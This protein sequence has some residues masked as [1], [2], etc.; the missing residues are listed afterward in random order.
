M[1]ISV[2]DI[3]GTFIKHSIF[4]GLELSYT[5]FIQTNPQLGSENMIQTLIQVLIEENAQSPL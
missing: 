2:F 4:N 3:G 1:K 5:Q